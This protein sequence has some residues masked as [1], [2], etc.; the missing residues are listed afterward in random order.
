[1][2]KVSKYDIDSPQKQLQWNLQTGNITAAHMTLWSTA[3][4]MTLL[5]TAAHMTLL[6]TA[7]HM[8]FSM[9]LLSTAAHMTL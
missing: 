2:F 6:S 3:A 7:A 9:T 4:H 5:A 1:M 8:T